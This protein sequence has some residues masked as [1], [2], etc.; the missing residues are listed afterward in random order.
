[1]RQAKIGDAIWQR[2][3]GSFASQPEGYIHAACYG[4]RGDAER[5]IAP[6]GVLLSDSYFQHKRA[7]SK[8]SSRRSPGRLGRGTSADPS[9]SWGGGDAAWQAVSGTAGA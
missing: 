7:H 5:L 8:H 9:G 6:F 3:P 4:G 2:E 1:M